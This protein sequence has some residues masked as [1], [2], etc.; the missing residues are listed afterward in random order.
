MNTRLKK[1]KNHAV[2]A[3]KSANQSQQKLLGKNSSSGFLNGGE[4]P[5]GRAGHGYNNGA[6][7]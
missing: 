7:Q 6:Q 1:K 2:F 3:E 5:W 4:V